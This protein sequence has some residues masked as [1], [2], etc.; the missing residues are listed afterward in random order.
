MMAAT[1]NIIN[2]LYATV[3]S[4]MAFEPV[5]LYHQERILPIGLVIQVFIFVIQWSVMMEICRAFVLRGEAKRSPHPCFY[6]T[7]VYT[8]MAVSACFHSHIMRAVAQV[9]PFRCFY[10]L[11]RLNGMVI[12]A[13]LQAKHNRCYCRYYIANC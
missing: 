5:F 12:P 4:I 11:H 3:N 7:L 10:I 2:M 8:F 6:K 13:A 1:N 9:L